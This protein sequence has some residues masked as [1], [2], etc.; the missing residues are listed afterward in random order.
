MASVEAR[1]LLERLG[2]FGVFCETGECNDGSE[3]PLVSMS[4]KAR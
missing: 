4:F 2:L 1:A 3:T